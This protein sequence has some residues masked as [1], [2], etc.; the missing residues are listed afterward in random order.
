MQAVYRV[1]EGLA[2]VAAGSSINLVP[3]RRETVFG[4]GFILAGLV[5]DI[6]TDAV[7]SRGFGDV[8]T[9]RLFAE[10]LNV[11]PALLLF[12]ASILSVMDRWKP[13]AQMTFPL[14]GRFLVCWACSAPPY[15]ANAVNF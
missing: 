7:S 9:C 5:N 1:A 6:V 2:G 8:V 14:W 3:D 10:L 4:R 11:W 12:Q 15:P 13:C